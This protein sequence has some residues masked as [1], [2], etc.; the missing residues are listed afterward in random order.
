MFYATHDSSMNRINENASIHAFETEAAARA[1][2]LSPFSPSEWDHS[3]AVIEEGRFGD[4]WV[5]IHG[6]PEIENGK[7]IVGAF[8]C[9]PFNAE[10]VRVATP[11][12]HPGGNVYWIEPSVPVLIVASIIERDSA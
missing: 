12:Q 7:L 11:G 10:Q 9:A 6:K 4:Y 8:D 1:W 2:L 3:T 5:K